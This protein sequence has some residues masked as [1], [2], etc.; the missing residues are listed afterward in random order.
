MVFSKKKIL[1]LG[2]FERLKKP[3]NNYNGSWIV[4][5]FRQ[6]A[7]SYNEA[8]HDNDALIKN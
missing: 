7:K 4:K 2:K 1:A 5:E 6:Y 8:I 3:N